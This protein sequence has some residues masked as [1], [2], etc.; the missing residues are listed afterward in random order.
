MNQN[1]YPVVYCSDPPVSESASV[2][3]TI[4]ASAITGLFAYGLGKQ[5]G[6]N[7]GYQQAKAEDTQVIEGLQQA[8][9]QA[10]VQRAFDS[11]KIGRLETQKNM[12]VELLQQQSPTPEIQAILKAV[13]RVSLQLAGFLPPMFENGQDPKP[14]WN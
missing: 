4:A 14:R 6:R 13:Q 7:E 2:G 3:P 11:E 8:L 5:H 9:A 10:Q 1:L 12:L